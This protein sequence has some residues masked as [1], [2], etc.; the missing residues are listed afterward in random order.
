M[1][2]FSLNFFKSL[3]QAARQL[4][5]QQDSFHVDPKF[6]QMYNRWKFIQAKVLL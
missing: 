2:H 3:Q 5:A 4:A 6:K 1:N